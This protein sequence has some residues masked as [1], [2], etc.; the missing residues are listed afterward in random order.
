MDLC[1][2]RT[3]VPHRE[4]G[5]QGRHWPFLC[6]DFGLGDTEGVDGVGSLDHLESSGSHDERTKVHEIERAKGVR[7]DRD[8]IGVDFWDAYALNGLG[9]F[10]A[11]ARL[12]LYHLVPSIRLCAYSRPKMA[13]RRH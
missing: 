7:P 10:E 1:V 4:V 11:L 6:S 3:F 2:S 13:R 12:A 9:T 8:C 5:S